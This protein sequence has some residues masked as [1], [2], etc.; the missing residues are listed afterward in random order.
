MT[1]PSPKTQQT[2]CES[3]E[4]RLQSIE[5][6][7]LSLMSSVATQATIVEQMSKILEVAVEKFDGFPKIMQEAIEPIQVQMA[8]IA[9]T[10]IELKHKEDERAEQA[11]KR[12][13]RWSVFKT[14][15]VTV[16]AATF[17]ALIKVVVDGH[18]FK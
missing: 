7:Q 4:A 16:I 10:A 3:H 11:R 2:L 15:M 6:S 12:T 14:A 9:D 5:N 18:F 8:S 17:G 1:P 13:A